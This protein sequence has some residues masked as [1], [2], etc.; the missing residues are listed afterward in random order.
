MFPVHSPLSHEGELI[1]NSST[2][3]ER[4]PVPRKRTPS[5]RI[6]TDAE[7]LRSEDDMKSGVIGGMIQKRPEDDEDKAYSK[8]QEARIVA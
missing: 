8:I 3:R 2:M 4:V 1:A 5:P 6:V 7:V